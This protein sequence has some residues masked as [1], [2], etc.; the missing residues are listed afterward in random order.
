M[1]QGFGKDSYRKGNSVKRFGPFTEP[2]DSETENL[3]S[4][5]P[6][7]KS[8]LIFWA[9]K[10]GH[11]RPCP[12]NGLT[13]KS[14]GGWPLSRLAG[15]TYS[16][17]SHELSV[18]NEPRESSDDFSLRKARPRSLFRPVQARSSKERSGPGWDQDGPGWPPPQD[19][20]WVR[21]A[22]K[23]STWRIWTGPLRTWDG[24]WTG[25]GEGLDGTPTD[26]NRPL[27]LSDTQ[28]RRLKSGKRKE[29]KSKL[30]GSDVSGGVSSA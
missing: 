28:T 4:S 2:P 12:E 21:S 9:S 20:D 26:S 23:Q 5:S 30:F 7:R 18:G 1:N 3:L 10:K 24:T 11:S 25:P 14:L 8:A 27:G 19:L 15:L 13:K 29:P 6:S 17:G 22:V 16:N